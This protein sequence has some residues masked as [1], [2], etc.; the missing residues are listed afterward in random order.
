MDAERCACCWARRGTFKNIFLT[1]T[2]SPRLVVALFLFFFLSLLS[3]KIKRH[4]PIYSTG[5]KDKSE[6]LSRRWVFCLTKPDPPPRCSLR[7]RR[8]AWALPG[9]LL[10][11]RRCISSSSSGSNAKRL[12]ISMKFSHSYSKSENSIFGDAR[13]L[14]ELSFWSFPADEWGVRRV[15]ARGHSKLSVCETETSFIFL[16]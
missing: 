6:R 10:P 7:C 8:T 14:S 12:Q 11:R 5:N 13:A 2:P 15:P 16:L 3:P 9:N 4:T 1:P